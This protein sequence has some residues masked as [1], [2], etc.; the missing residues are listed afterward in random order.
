[1]AMTVAAEPEMAAKLV[2]ID[3]VAEW[4]S[5]YSFGKVGSKDRAAGIAIVTPERLKVKPTHYLVCTPAQ[6]SNFGRLGSS[7]STVRA[8]AWL[9]DLQCLKQC[10]AVVVADK[11]AEIVIAMRVHSELLSDDDEAVRK[12]DKFDRSRLRRIPGR[13][14]AEI[15]KTIEDDEND[16]ELDPALADALGRVGADGPGENG[17]VDWADKTR[18][19]HAAGSTMAS[20]AGLA[21]KAARVAKRAVEEDRGEVELLRKH[22]RVEQ[23]R[24]GQ[25]TFTFEGVAELNLCKSL[26]VIV[27]K[28]MP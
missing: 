11:R 10:L 17:R 26:N 24:G 15:K 20:C 12:M 7:N 27:T 6:L 18:F 22:V 13:V 5:T 19:K 21:T 9:L 1:M 2:P 28:A 14:L 23:L 8:A 4:R 3:D 16:D 25:L